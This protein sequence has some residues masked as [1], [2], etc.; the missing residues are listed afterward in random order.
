MSTITKY[1]Y[2]VYFLYDSIDNIPKYI[3]ITRRTLKQRLLEHIEISKRQKKRYKNV[4]IRKLLRNNRKPKIKLLEKLYC[5][6]QEAK[7]LEYQYINL[8]LDKGYKL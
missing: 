5:T 7:T 8:Y 4:W 1:N 2:K 6:E 3:G